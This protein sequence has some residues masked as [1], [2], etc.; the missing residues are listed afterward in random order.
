M[1]IVTPSLLYPSSKFLR[2][3]AGWWYSAP[4][5]YGTYTAQ[6]LF[7]GWI[8]LGTVFLVTS[9]P[10][11]TQ[12]TSRL[13]GHTLIVRWFQLLGCRFDRSNLCF[14]LTSSWRNG[15]GSD[16]IDGKDDGLTAEVHKQDL[17]LETHQ[18][19]EGKSLEVFDLQFD[20][21]VYEHG[22]WASL[23]SVAL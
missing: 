6:T 7:T 15:A 4:L 11:S 20:P 17:C 13:V 3:H 19:N 5:M 18:Y 9:M 8:G 12:L 10:I 2:K 22:K 23:T 21:Y 14:W 16:G 1:R